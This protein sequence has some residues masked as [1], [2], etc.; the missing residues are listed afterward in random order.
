MWFV[1]PSSWGQYFRLFI[2]IKSHNDC[3]EVNDLKLNMRYIC[4]I[5]LCKCSHSS[6][7]NNVCMFCCMPFWWSYDLKVGTQRTMSVSSWHVEKWA[8]TLS[9]PPFETLCFPTEGCVILIFHDVIPSSVCSSG[10]QLLHSLVGAWA[11]VKYKRSSSSIGLQT[12]MLHGGSWMH[13]C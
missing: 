13:Q 3:C 7:R 12:Q 8:C 2:I 9:Q 5:P 6:I 1:S 4:F 11:A 10:D